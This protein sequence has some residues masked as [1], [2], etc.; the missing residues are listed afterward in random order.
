VITNDE[1]QVALR[2]IEEACDEL[3]TLKGRKEEKI[4]PPGEKH[5]VIG[6]DD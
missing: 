2:I 6:L 3:P 4:L 1:I 5:V